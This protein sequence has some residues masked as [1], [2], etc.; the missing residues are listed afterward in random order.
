MKRML[1]STLR[2]CFVS[3]RFPTRGYHPEYAYLWPLLKTMAGLGHDIS[4]I[5]TEETVTTEVETR[6]GV[7]IYNLEKSMLRNIG[8][9]V[10]EAILERFEQLQAEKPFHI[11]HCTDR[12]AHYLAKNR[13]HLKAAFAIDVRASSLDDL[14]GVMG[15]TQE[16][17]W[18]Y[19][20]TGFSISLRFLRTYWKWD[21]RLFRSADGIFA[22]SQQQQIILERYYFVPEKRTFVIPLGIEA[23]ELISSSRDLE[24]AHKLGIPEDSQ[25]VVTVSRMDQVG[26][27]KNLITAF[28]RVA[29]KK[30]N[31]VLIIVGDGPKLFEVEGFALSYAL[32]NRV[33]F[34]REVPAENVKDYI[35]LADVYV[36]LDSRSSGLEPSVLQAM[37]NKKMVIASEV[38]TNASV[39]E[40]GVDGFLVHPTVTQDIAMLILDAFSGN[41]DVQRVGQAAHHKILKMFDTRKMVEKTISSYKEILKTARVPQK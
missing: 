29:I 17:V 13:R 10:E 9:P 33:F 6:D 12:T 19:I 41:L 31:A 11:V 28:E 32:G 21:R 3:Q 2:I 1:P 22:V 30:P 27:L 7:T 36:N 15:L 35:N 34:A 23:P 25:I 18:S 24:L 16:T 5:T 26:A 39:I 20:R 37:L 4:V 40:N 38:G 14:F 8:M